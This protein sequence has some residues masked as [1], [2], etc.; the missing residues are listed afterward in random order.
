MS[1]GFWFLLLCVYVDAQNYC[2]NISKQGRKE[3]EE[4]RKAMDDNGDGES[5]I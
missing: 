4:S 1:T 3:E 2:N 5:T